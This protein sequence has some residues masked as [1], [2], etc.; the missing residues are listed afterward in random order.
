MGFAE[1]FDDYLTANDI[2]LSKLSSKT[3]ID[4][5]VLF[6]YRSGKYNP[7]NEEIVLRIAEALQMSVDERARFVQEFDKAVMGENMVYSY[8]YVMGL[9]SDMY[10]AKEY[11]ISAYK[12][13]HIDISVAESLSED[14]KVLSNPQQ[15]KSAVLDLFSNAVRQGCDKV[16]IL[17]Q[18]SYKEIQS[19]IFPAFRNSNLAIE[20]IICLEKSENYGYVNLEFLREAVPLCFEINKYKVY[21]H[22]DTLASRF[23]STV[24]LPNFILSDN[25]VVTFDYELSSGVLLR[26]KKLVDY[27]KEQF[28]GLRQQCAKLINRGDYF[29]SIH[30]MNAVFYDRSTEL[31]GFSFFNEPCIS[32]CLSRGLLENCIYDIPGK[33]EFVDRLVLEN[34]DWDGNKYVPYS[35]SEYTVESYF[36]KSGLRD[37]M[38]TGRVSEFPIELHMPLSREY[39]MSVIDHM[40]ILMEK[41]FVKYRVFE[42]KTFVLPS[43]VNFYLGVDVKTLLIRYVHSTKITQVT[44]TEGSIIDTFMNYIEYNQ[45]KG[46]LLSEEESL[47]WIK[48]YR[49]EIRREWNL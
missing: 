1:Y 38:E 26:E 36:T 7:Q 18:P 22:Y 14:N 8:N 20:Q 42:P 3:G 33:K 23:N 9:L 17:M 10:N 34:G 35:N 27:C 19:L 24:I 11:F 28:E 49:N 45:R 47:A 37:I 29:N 13:P 30:A 39:R 46:I 25:E 31:R 6:R 12:E 43:T 5:S 40:V 15:V 48:E 2:S 44:V 32:L 41:G 21:Y 16:G 4:R